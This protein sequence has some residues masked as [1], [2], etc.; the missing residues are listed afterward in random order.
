LRTS[1]AP[2]EE[3]QE[4]YVH[5]PQ[6]KRKKKKHPKAGTQ[7]DKKRGGEEFMPK[8]VEAVTQFVSMCGG[9]GRQAALEE[10]RKERGDGK[11]RKASTKYLRGGGGIG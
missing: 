4:P 7:G 5:P 10:V 1:W 3:L 6:G 11:R 8:R 2:M 9:E